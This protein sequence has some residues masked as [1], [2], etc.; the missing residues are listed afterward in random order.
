MP[1]DKL[2][3]ALKDYKDPHGTIA[4]KTMHFKYNAGVAGA[5]FAANEWALKL[6]Y[7]L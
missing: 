6:W 7:L 5:K 4:V 3:E 1:R 2:D